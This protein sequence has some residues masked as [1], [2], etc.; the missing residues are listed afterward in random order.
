M[1]YSI[2]GKYE[3]AVIYRKAEQMFLLFKAKANQRFL[4]LETC[5]VNTVKH[6]YTQQ[7][8]KRIQAH[9][10]YGIAVKKLV[11]GFA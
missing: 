6:W 8:K 3:A 11:K 9:S 1:I 10:L 2:T 5:P 4:C 7:S